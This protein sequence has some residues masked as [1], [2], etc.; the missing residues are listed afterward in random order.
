MKTIDGIF[1]DRR[2]RVT[3]ARVL[4]GPDTRLASDHLPVLAELELS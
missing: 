4:E 2:I 3:A 1:V